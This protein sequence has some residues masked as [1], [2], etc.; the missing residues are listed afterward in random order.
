AYGVSV[1]WG[2][3]LRQLRAATWTLPETLR[4]RMLPHEQSVWTHRCAGI[5]KD[6]FSVQ[7]DDG[8]LG[9]ELIRIGNVRLKE[10]LIAV[11][12]AHDKS[13]QT[14]AARQSYKHMYKFVA[15]AGS[16]AQHNIQRAFFLCGVSD[17]LLNSALSPDEIEIV[18]FLDTRVNFLDLVFRAIGRAHD[19]CGLD[20]GIRQTPN[21]FLNRFAPI[22]SLFL[23]KLR[24][25]GHL[26]GAVIEVHAHL[27][28]RG[29]RRIGF[30]HERGNILKF[31]FQSVVAAVFDF[32]ALW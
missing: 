22:L 30:F 26:S 12:H 28:D 18:D 17:H 10:I 23:P 5:E 19:F 14:C 6:I 16:V 1:S 29:R 27:H 8:D 32:G 9:S 20:R 4:G 31:Q 24:A 13:R 11:S 21:R 7:A 3:R 15:V 25:L 2:I